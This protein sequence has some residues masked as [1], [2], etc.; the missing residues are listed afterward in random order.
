METNK[1]A[2]ERSKLLEVLIVPC[3]MET[4]YD[5]LVIRLDLVLIV[6]CGMETCNTFLY[7]FKP[8]TC[9]NCTLRNGNEDEGVFIRDILGIN[10][11]LRNGNYVRI[12]KIV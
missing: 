11:T 5:K 6:P 12:D 3:G 4:Y 1:S 2:A 7:H 9:I 10:C 8:T